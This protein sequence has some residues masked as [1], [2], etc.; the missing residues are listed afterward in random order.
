MEKE[1]KKKK[2][3]EDFMGRLGRGVELVEE[4]IGICVEEMVYLSH[5]NI[6]FLTLFGWFSGFFMK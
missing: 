1:K 5:Q 4:G 2:R 6:C 3:T